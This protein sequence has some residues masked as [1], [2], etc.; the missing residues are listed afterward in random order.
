MK[1][2]LFFLCA[3]FIIAISFSSCEGLLENCE[4]CR[5]IVYVDGTPDPG[6][7]Y[8]E[9]EYCNAELLTLKAASP[10]VVGNKTTKFECD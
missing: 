2:K 4:N 1:K 5:Y 3:L 7:T 6:L 10:I 9:A 8:G